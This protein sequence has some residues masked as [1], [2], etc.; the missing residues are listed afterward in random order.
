M[1]MGVDSYD[2]PLSW[3]FVH[4]L[5]IALPLVVGGVIGRRGRLRLRDIAAIVAVAAVV[6][7]P[8]AACTRLNRDPAAWIPMIAGHAASSPGIALFGVT[9]PGWSTMLGAG[10]LGCGLGA[11]LFRSTR[12]GQLGRVESP[13]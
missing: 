1:A 4:L 13:K 11:V 5:L 12:R 10:V 3:V 8:A 9:V 2:G 6:M 7:L